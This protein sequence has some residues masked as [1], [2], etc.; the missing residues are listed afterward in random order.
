MAKREC[1]IGELAEPFEM[2]LAGVSKHIKVLERAGLIRRARDGRI[3]RCSMDYRP[4]KEASE[5]IAYYK[6]FWSDRFDQL[7]DFLKGGSNDR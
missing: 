4:L 5:L 1:T 7:E 2:T 6:R 3:H